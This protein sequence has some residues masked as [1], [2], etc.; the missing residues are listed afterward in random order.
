MEIGGFRE[1]DL[2]QGYEF[3]SGNNVARLNS[4]RYGIFHALQLLGCSKIL[5]PYYQCDTVRDYL[6]SQNIEIEYY[7]IDSNFYPILNSV[8]EKDRALLI[9][10]YFGIISANYL[11]EVIEKNPNVIVDN[12]QA[13]FSAPIPASYTVYSPRK[14]FGV[15]DGCYVYGENATHLLEKY[16]E[17]LSSPTSSFL[18]SRIETGGNANYQNYCINEERISSSGLRRMSKLTHALLDN[19]DYEYCMNKRRENFKI[20][21][22]LFDSINCISIANINVNADLCIPMVYPLVIE[23]EDLRNKL[24][25]NRIYIGHWWEYLINELPFNSIEVYYSKFLIPIQIDH[26]YDRKHIQYVYELI[27]RIVEEDHT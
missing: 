1:L 10:N 18:L 27:A 11:S 13:F 22:D 15:P 6:L 19:I 7:H 23:N 4:G 26:R 9:V 21:C 16:E 20:A 2:R 17:D 8:I 14:F 5:M 25:S 12:T 24:V 3:Y